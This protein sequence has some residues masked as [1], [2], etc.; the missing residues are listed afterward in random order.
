M[1]LY[2]RTTCKGK[3]QVCGFLGDG[4]EVPVLALTCKNEFGWLPPGFMI[5]RT[6]DALKEFTLKLVLRFQVQ[7]RKVEGETIQ[8]TTLK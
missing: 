5:K 1:I 8:S 2:C 4:E 3:I 6:L 7:D